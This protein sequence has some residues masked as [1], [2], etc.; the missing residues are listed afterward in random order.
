MPAC[1][2][3]VPDER[4]GQ[5]RREPGIQSDPVPEHGEPG[6]ADG[7]RETDGRD[8]VRIEEGDDEHR[9]DVVGNR[10]AREATRAATG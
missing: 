10:D 1:M 8:A 6:A 5:E 7:D 4:A 9:G 3:A 2:Q